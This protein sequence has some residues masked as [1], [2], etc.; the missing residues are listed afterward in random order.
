MLYDVSFQLV[1]IKGK[2]AILFN[3]GIADELPLIEANGAGKGGVDRAIDQD[4]IAFF[5]QG[6]NG[7]RNGWHHSFD[8]DDIFFLNV[9]AMLIFLPIDNGLIETVC[10]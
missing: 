1:K 9:I 8:K 6:L 3:Q 2:L 4:S 5:G 7:H 10:K